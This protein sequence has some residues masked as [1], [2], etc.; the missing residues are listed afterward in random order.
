M[1]DRLT[2]LQ[3]AVDQLAVQFYSAIHYLST[4]HDFVPLDGS[5][6]V[7]D[8]Q[9][10]PDDPAVFESAKAEL[11]RD[12]MVKTR[13]IDLLIASLPGAGVTEQ[14]QLQRVQRLE[15]ELELAE[16]ERLRW[17]MRRKELLAKCD[18][19]ILQLTKSKNDISS[20]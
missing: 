15:T 3:D 10:Q 19:I 4:H 8:P 5:A 12:I 16:Q 7:S 1:T 18:S 20:A 2:Q 14:D 9:L 6:K 17:L 11:A 13:Q